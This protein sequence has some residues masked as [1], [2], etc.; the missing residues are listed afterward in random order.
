MELFIDG[1][2]IYNLRSG[3]A[4][5]FHSTGSTARLVCGAH[6]PS[7]ADRHCLVPLCPYAPTNRPVVVK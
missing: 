2:F 5:R 7:H 1:E 6:S 4:D 3:R